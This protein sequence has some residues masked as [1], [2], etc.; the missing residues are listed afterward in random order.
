M[1]TGM[2]LQ[3]RLT[4]S[5]IGAFY[6]VYNNLGFGFLEV[7]LLLHFGPRPKFYRVLCENHLKRRTARSVESVASV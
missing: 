4:R 3:E 1:T 6:E 5:V 2:L 7:G